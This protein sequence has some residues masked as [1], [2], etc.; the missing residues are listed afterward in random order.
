MWMQKVCTQQQGTRELFFQSTGYGEKTGVQWA[1]TKEGVLV[2]SKFQV[3][4]M[5]ETFSTEVM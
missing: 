5:C 4:R 1:T 3:E 2:N